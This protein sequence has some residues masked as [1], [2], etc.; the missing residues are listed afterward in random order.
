MARGKRPAP[1]PD[2]PPKSCARRKYL[3]GLTASAADPSSTTFRPLSDL[4]R[5]Y[6][7][8]KFDLLSKSNRPIFDDISTPLRRILKPSSTESRPIFN[9]ISTHLH[10]NLDPSSPKFRPIFTDI[11]THLQRNIDPSSP[12][13]PSIFDEISTITFCWLSSETPQ[14]LED[15]GLCRRPLLDQLLTTFR[16]LFD[17]LSVYF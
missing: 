2:P 10:R 6:F 3:G 9:E 17:L 11:S 8:S 13:F 12:T 5:T 1:H 14:A 15:L 7:W 4:F 16:P